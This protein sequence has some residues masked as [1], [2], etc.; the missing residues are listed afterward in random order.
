MCLQEAGV[1]RLHSLRQG[2]HVAAWFHRKCRFQQ[3][4]LAAF[5]EG[6]QHILRPSTQMPEI[7]ALPGLAFLNSI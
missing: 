5:S 6:R 1:I 2:E 4:S 3:N 7:I